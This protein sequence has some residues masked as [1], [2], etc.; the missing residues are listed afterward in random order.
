[1]FVGEWAGTLV[2]IAV[3]A[4]VW[5]IVARYVFNAPTMWAHVT[6]TS[7]TGVT[8]LVAGAYVLQRGEFIRMTVLV[9]RAGPKMRQRL[10]LLADITA[11]YWGAILVYGASLQAEKSIFRFRGGE[12]RP[13]T[14]G[15]AWDVPIPALIRLLFA[16]G[17]ALF[18]MQALVIVYRR[19]RVVR[20]ADPA[21]TP[22]DGSGSGD[23]IVDPALAAQPFVGREKL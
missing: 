23:G 12:W 1:M 13:E 21:D 15:G 11:V 5:E 9:E 16:L 20:G 14:T 18:L 22:V 19:L 2:I 3:L 7:L 17:V 10:N 6:T 8:Y 4:T